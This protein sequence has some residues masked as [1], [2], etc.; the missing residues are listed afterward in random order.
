MLK[1]C[2]LHKIHLARK[3]SILH[4]FSVPQEFVFN[5]F[6]QEK[7]NFMRCSRQVTSKK[8]W[9]WQYTVCTEHGAENFNTLDTLLAKLEEVWYKHN[10]TECPIP[11]SYCVPKCARVTYYLTLSTTWKTIVNVPLIVCAGTYLPT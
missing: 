11:D 6:Q 10:T 7:S 2:S 8:R 3:K 5:W 4:S 9:K 1:Y